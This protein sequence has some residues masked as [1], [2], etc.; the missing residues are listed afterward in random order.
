LLVGRRPIDRLVV[1]GRGQGGD[2]ERSRRGAGGEH[3]NQAEDQP[4]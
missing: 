3:S 4:A 2:G 1:V